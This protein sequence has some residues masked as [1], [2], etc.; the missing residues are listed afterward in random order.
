MGGRGSRHPLHRRHGGGAWLLAPYY[1]P[2]RQTLTLHTPAQPPAQQS[3]AAAE[4]KDSLSGAVQLEALYDTM[5]HLTVVCNGRFV[6]TQ[7]NR[8][9]RDYLLGKLRESGYTED[10]GT[11][12]LQDFRIDIPVEKPVKPAK[13]ETDAGTSSD[14]AGT[15][16]QAEDSADGSGNKKEQKTET[17]HVYYDTQNIIATLPAKKPDAPVYVIS[18]HYD[19]VYNVPGAIDNASGCAAVLELA[20]VCAASGRDFG[21]ELRFI[22]FSGEE[23]GL[24]GSK[25]YLSKLSPDEL[26]R[27]KGQ[28]NIDMAGPGTNN[29]HSLLTCS[30]FGA[31]T[32]G[33]YVTGT[34][35]APV[36]NTVSRAA[37]AAYAEN[38]EGIAEFRCPIHWDKNDLRPFH[39]AHI[40]AVTLSW[41]EVD[42]AR[43]ETQDIAAPSLMHTQSDSLD[44]FDMPALR[45]TTCFA[46]DTLTKLLSN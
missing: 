35:E 34:P 7:G 38:S 39:W 9:A 20:R 24:Y 17:Y 3:P 36:D 11:L 42:P 44:N 45:K 29:A 46:A 28:L 43:A 21:A 4:K 31:N 22:F 14:S 6:D 10:A 18:C 5:Y 37:Q 32:D 30:T 15:N 25:F 27:H 19:A 41:R 12:A 1:L 26:A 2:A 33:G 23:L 13:K 16:K 40:D 8:D